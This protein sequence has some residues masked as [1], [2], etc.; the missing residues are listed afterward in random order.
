MKQMG[1]KMRATLAACL[2]VAAFALAGGLAAGA[3]AEESGGARANVSYKIYNI[4]LSSG[5]D[6]QTLYINASDYVI[7]TNNDVV[8]RSIV[9]DTGS[10][11]SAPMMNPGQ[12]YIH[13][14]NTP[15]NYPYHCAELPAMTG[16]VVVN[17]TVPE[18][19][20]PAAAVA[21]GAL[22]GVIA[23]IFAAARRD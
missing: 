7:W 14:F 17:A 20:G 4:S 22:A 9:S 10:E 5:F 21:A 15:G 23:L 11:I 13:Q 1:S 18:S 8:P 2:I 19:A 16:T 3:P 12:K 6:P